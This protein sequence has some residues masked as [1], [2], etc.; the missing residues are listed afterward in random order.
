[1]GTI[2]KLTPQLYGAIIDEAHKLDMRVAVHATGLDDAK[3][4]L[5]A[6]I[7]IF[8]HMISDVDDELVGLFKQRPKTAVLLALG[9]PRRTI[10]APWLDPPPPPPRAAVS[11]EQIERLRQRLAGAKPDALERDRAAWNRLA[12]G[13]A[14]LNA[15]GVRIGVG[16][17]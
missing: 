7:D 12:R 9:G 4:L 1:G 17:D 2:R 14:R 15:A 6:G 11:A 10:Y 13:I 16:T 3:N 8:A 5:R